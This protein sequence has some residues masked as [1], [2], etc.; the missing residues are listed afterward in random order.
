[1]ATETERIAGLAKVGPV[2][3]AVRRMTADAGK[4]LAAHGMEAVRQTGVAG[5]ACAIDSVR[6]QV[7]MFATARLVT[8][9][10]LALQ[11]FGV[12]GIAKRNRMA[13][14][15]IATQGGR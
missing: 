14:M 7:T 9:H 11:H 8:G 15:T 1:M 3:A 2:G 4:S 6:Q 10:A 12:A 5:I 13:G